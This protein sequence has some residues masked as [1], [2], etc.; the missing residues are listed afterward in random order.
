MRDLEIGHALA[1]IPPMAGPAQ[2]AKPDQRPILIKGRV[3][4][5]CILRNEALK[6]T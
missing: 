4:H 3:L 2:P 5:V 1:V 6:D